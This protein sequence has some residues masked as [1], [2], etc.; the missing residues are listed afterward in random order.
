MVDTWRREGIGLRIGFG[1]VDL[2]LI[3]QAGSTWWILGAVNEDRIGF[4]GVDLGIPWAGVRCLEKDCI[5]GKRYPYVSIN[6]RIAARFH[7]GSSMDGHAH[8]GFQ[9]RARSLHPCTGRTPPRAVRSR[10][11]GLRAVSGKN[12]TE[13]P[14]REA[15]VT[16]LALLVVVASR[17]ADDTSFTRTAVQGS[18]A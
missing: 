16:R 10:M 8:H 14:R 18:S 9:V 13:R 12:I 7:D 17:C 6:R 1:R 5:V 2:G 4:G 15:Q 3:S 11:S